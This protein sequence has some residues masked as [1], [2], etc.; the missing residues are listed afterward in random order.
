MH[1]LQRELDACQQL[2]ETARREVHELAH[3]LAEGRRQGGPSRSDKTFSSPA[4]TRFADLDPSALSDDLDPSALSE[5]PTQVRLKA[6]ERRPRMC[7]CVC[8][9]V[10][11]RMYV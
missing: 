9:C 1:T 8:V 10:C 2:L 4:L 11:M 6:G 3:E 5:K 7:V